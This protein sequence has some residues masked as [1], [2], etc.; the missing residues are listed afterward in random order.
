MSIRNTPK[1]LIVI[2]G[3]TASG[4]SEMALEL[5]K[6][7][8]GEIISADS[9][10]IY[11]GMDIATAKPY[12]GRRKKLKGKGS[13]KAVIINGIP[14]YLINIIEPNKDFSV[15]EYRNLVLKIIKDIHSRGKV[16]FL[17]GGTGFYISSITENLELPQ[18]PP[19]KKLRKKLE[20]LTTRQL[21]SKLKKIDPKKA[22]IIDA[23]NPHRLI[24]AIEI[25]MGAKKTAAVKTEKLKPEL[26]ILR[27]GID[28]PRERLYK[29]ID[30]RVEK[31]IK[32][33]LVQ[34]TKKLAGK[35]SWKLP[36]MSG[37]GYKQMGMYLRSEITLPE[38]KEL[39]KFATH[40]Y[41]RR[42]MTWF[43]K[44]RSIRWADSHSKAKRLIKSFLKR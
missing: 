20:K 36:S 41:A 24:R 32:Q 23:K 22:K 31:M 18:I 14:H 39:M 1:P 15:A 9:R 7:F 43:R 2:L 33:G 10:Q 26:D 28:I 30:Q 6:S 13:K 44:D 40:A 12:L 35:Y 17:V 4:K 19:N 3:P 16:P 37:I 42:Q 27:I 21:F 38:A 25:A 5:A 11:K 34:E 8:N 29:K